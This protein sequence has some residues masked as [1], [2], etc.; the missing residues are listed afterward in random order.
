MPW[1][2][3]FDSGPWYAVQH[4]SQNVRDGISK[5]QL[6]KT[7]GR[8]MT[9]KELWN[10]TI[11]LHNK[12]VENTFW[13]RLVVISCNKMST[14]LLQIAHLCVWLCR[15][16]VFC[17]IDKMCIFLTCFILYFYGLYLPEPKVDHFIVVTLFCNRIDFYLEIF[18]CR[19]INHTQVIFKYCF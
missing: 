5:T 18:C 16:K 19:F 7:I 4:C 12:H 3:Y 10:I 17:P 11:F 8:G 1:P 15:V 13:Y 9:K 6:C 2:K 14:E